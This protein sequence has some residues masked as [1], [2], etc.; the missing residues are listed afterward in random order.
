MRETAKRITMP[1]LSKTRSDFEII[2]NQYRALIDPEDLERIDKALKD[3]AIV[4]REITFRTKGAIGAFPT[5]PVVLT[6]DTMNMLFDP[7]TIESIVKVLPPTEPR[8]TLHVF[9]GIPRIDDES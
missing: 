5:T 1:T 4:H 2:F 7:G 8:A 3:A 6:S 9:T